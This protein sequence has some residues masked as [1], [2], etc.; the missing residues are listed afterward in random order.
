[1]IKHILTDLAVP[2]WIERLTSE[3]SH[4]VSQ[5]QLRAEFERLVE[6]LD[7]PLQD[8]TIRDSW[9]HGDCREFCRLSLFVKYHST[10]RIREGGCGLCTKRHW[11]ATWC[12]LPSHINEEFEIAAQVA[13]EFDRRYPELGIMSIPP[14]WWQV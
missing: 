8:E 9:L 4:I 12:M 13:M 5:E 10:Y 7:L 2:G 11:L 1:M 3:E 6:G 14:G